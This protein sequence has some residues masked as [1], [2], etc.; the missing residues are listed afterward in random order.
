MGNPALVS[1]WGIQ[2]VTR[3]AR[4]PKVVREAVMVY[5]DARDRALLERVAL[6]TGLPRTELLRRGLWQVASRELGDARPGSA[7]DYL[8]ETASDQAVPPD[9]SERPDHYL[10]GGGYERWFG[11]KKRKPPAKKKRARL[12]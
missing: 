1:V 2:G 3:M 11:D 10:Y 12:R 8:I 7:F 4:K 6:K 9:L 5:L